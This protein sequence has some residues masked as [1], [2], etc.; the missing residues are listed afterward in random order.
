MP[1]SVVITTPLPT[2]E[3]TANFYGLSKADRKFVTRL[4]GGAGPASAYRF[5]PHSTASKPGENGALLETRGRTRKT[6][7]R[8]RKAA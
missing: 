2:W 5:K 6:K 7:S 4:V 1:R 8:A 3:E